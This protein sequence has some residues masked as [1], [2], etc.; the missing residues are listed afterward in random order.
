LEVSRAQ[1]SLTMMC[2]YGG[3]TTEHAEDAEKTRKSFFWF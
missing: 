1:T 3:V 2:S